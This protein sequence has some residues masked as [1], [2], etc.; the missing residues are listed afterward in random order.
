MLEASK[1]ISEPHLE[2]M[3]YQPF[4]PC[5]LTA[6]MTDEALQNNNSQI[7]G[8]PKYEIHLLSSIFAS[9][10]PILMIS[11]LVNRSSLH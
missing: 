5:L 3:G 7:Q 6:S 1:T 10:H 2:K 11:D 8:D 4:Q 9:F